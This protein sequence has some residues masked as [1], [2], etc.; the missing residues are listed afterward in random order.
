[1]ENFMKHGIATCAV[2]LF[3]MVS[4]SGAFAQSNA[5]SFVSSQGND[6]NACTVTAP[7]RFLQSAMGKTQAGG[8]VRCMDGAFYAAL[9]ITKAITISCDQGHAMIGGNTN[10][11]RIEIYAGPND[12][13]VLR[14]ILTFG[15]DMFTGHAGL[16]FISGASLRIENSVIHENRPDHGIE[17]VPSTGTPKLFI[18]N[19]V[20]ATN[21]SGTTGGG[22]QIAPTG[23][24]GAEVHIDGTKILDNTVGIRADARGT[25]GTINV[26]ISDT[27]VS[28]GTYHGVVALGGSGRVRMMLDGV[29]SSNN[30]HEGV[31]AVGPNVGVRIGRSTVSYNGTGITA[32]NGGNVL[33][34]GTNQI[35]GNTVDG[36]T[37]PVSAQ[38]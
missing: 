7:C 33:S 30:S 25:T 35:D 3:T 10:A 21:G 24:A 8:E 12:D 15:G 38:K 18:V 34:Y 6:T 1:M 13:V 32:L 14:G 9:L 17:F 36:F 23:S 19:S 37:P 2:A 5:V 20:I 27:V 29:V 26:T 28:G 11:A 4:A 22:I 16:R 31:R